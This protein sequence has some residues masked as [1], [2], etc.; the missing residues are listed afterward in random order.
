MLKFDYL[1]DYLT[2]FC[3][4]FVGFTTQ[5]CATKF[6]ASELEWNAVDVDGKS[7]APY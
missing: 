4:H 7:Y 3:L 6:W 2:F 5:L 1:C